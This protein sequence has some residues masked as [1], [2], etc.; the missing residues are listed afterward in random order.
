M[1]RMS[2]RCTSKCV[3]KLCLSECRFAG[4]SMA[5]AF[6]IPRPQQHEQVLRQHGLAIP[7]SLALFHADQHAFA[8]DVGTRQVDDFAGPKARPVG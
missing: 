2:S 6:P 7:G 4:L 8:V 3:A 1:T 5:A